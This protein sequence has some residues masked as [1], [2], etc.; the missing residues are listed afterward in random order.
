[1]ADEASW[2]VASPERKTWSRRGR[3]D[4]RPR[5]KGRIR[6]RYVGR[7]VSGLR[8]ALGGGEGLRVDV[9]I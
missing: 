5:S 2:E 9:G 1:M 3:P 7:D 6:G 4:G 8:K